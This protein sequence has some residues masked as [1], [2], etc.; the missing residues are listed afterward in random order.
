MIKGRPP[1]LTEIFQSQTDP[2]FFLTF[3]TL[4]RHKFPCLPLV[5]QTLRKYAERGASDF[6]L[7]IGRYI[8]MPDHVHLF[9]RGSEDFVLT[10]WI[11]G[12]KRAISSA[13]AKEHSRVRW[14]PGFFD[15]LLRNEESYGEKWAYVRDNPVRAGL[16]D[17][18][19]DWPY[20]GELVV[21]DR[22]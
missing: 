14:Q 4:H 17:C 15:H 10:E 18:F 22:F 8:M 12:L 7:A 9:V 5:D 1:R 11:K 6:N 19:D 20:Q 21:I 16:V 3:C 13:S 2:L